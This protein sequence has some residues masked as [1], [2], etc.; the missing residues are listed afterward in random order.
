MP[1]F[2]IVA[3]FVLLLTWLS[4]LHGASLAPPTRWPRTFLE[5]RR[6]HFDIVQTG[7]WGRLLFSLPST[8]GCANPRL[9]GTF[10][11]LQEVGGQLPGTLQVQPALWSYRRRTDWR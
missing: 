6:P 7:V 8:P 1:R 2:D 5:V 3:L 9:Y 11:S 10:C 4:S